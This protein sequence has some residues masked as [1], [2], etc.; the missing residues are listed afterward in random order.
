MKTIILLSAIV[1]LL[2]HNYAADT[3]SNEYHIYS[4]KTWLS[5]L[6]DSK[7]LV[8]KPLHWELKDWLIL[9][10]V[11]VATAGCMLVDDEIKNRV[12]PNRLPSIDN[13]SSIAQYGG[14]GFVLVPGLALWYAGGELLNNTRMRRSAVVAF[15]SFVYSGILANVVKYSLHRHRP[16]YSDRSTLYNGPSLSTD[17]NF[18][19]FVSGHASTAFSIA[20]V[21][22]TEYQDVAWVPIVAYSLATLVALSRIN[23]NRHWT[24]DVLA[25][26]A[27]GWAVGTTLSKLNSSE[28]SIT[29]SPVFSGSSLGICVAVPIK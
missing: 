19:S 26:A 16:D 15:E 28:S 7:N 1:S 17:D 24:S 27:I 5:C 3:T 23:D 14:N 4:S 2:S 22:A 8:C 21:F 20:S 29:I 9:G 6:D 10:G 11:G 18:H 25:G 12:Q 13:L